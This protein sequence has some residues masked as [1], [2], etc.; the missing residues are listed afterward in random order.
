M[1]LEAIKY[2]PRHYK[3]RLLLAEMYLKNNAI[4]D[5]KREATNVLRIENGNLRAALILAQC[6]VIEKD[7]VKSKK[8]LTQIQKVLP[9][10]PRSYNIMGISYLSEG[11][12][13]AAMA[14]FEKVLELAPQS[15]KAMGYIV[16]ILLKQDKADTAMQR[17]KVQA[18]KFP[19]NPALLMQQGLLAMRLK[20]N[21]LAEQSFRQ[22]I[23]LA[24]Q[25]AAPYTMLGQILQKTGKMEEAISQ[26]KTA[27]QDN[28]DLVGV[29]MQLGILLE[30]QG[31]S[32]KASEEYRKILEKKP[33]FAPAANNLAW[34]LSTHNADMGE[35]LRLAMVAKSVS[36]ED[37]NVADTVGWVHYKRGSYGLARTQFAEAQRMLPKNAIVNYHLGL[38]LAK[39]KETTQAKIYLQKAIALAKGSKDFPDLEAARQL[40]RK[41]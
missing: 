23:K 9:K 31:Q 26:Y 21:N 35:A 16:N 27:L 10:D 19:K 18:A 5:A 28:P 36:P 22:A 1:A 2:S 38:A 3:A 40:L 30:K 15:D 4:D 29:R 14:Q 33:E 37:P 6:L 17:I 13:D 41:L 11:Q 25:L 8:L 7:Y 12:L 24:P 20:N 34:Y 32:K 39:L